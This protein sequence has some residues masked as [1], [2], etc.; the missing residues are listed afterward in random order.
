MGVIVSEMR[1]KASSFFGS[2]YGDDYVMATET[3]KAAITTAMIASSARSLIT[4]MTTAMTKAMTTAMTT[5][6]A[7]S[8]STAVVA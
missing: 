4:A 6:S 3:T 7:H 1:S 2:A 5:H 8:F